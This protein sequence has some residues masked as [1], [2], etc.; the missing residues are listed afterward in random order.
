MDGGGP[1]SDATPDDAG[2]A[3]P[4]L[5]LQTGEPGRWVPFE[6]GDEVLL[7]R[8][9]QGSQHVYV[10]ARV[11]GAAEGPVRLSLTV[12]R[13]R[14]GEVVSLPFELR[15]PFEARPEGGWRQ[16]TGLTPVVPVPAD[17][18]DEEVSIEGRVTDEAGRSGEAVRRARVVW[19]PDACG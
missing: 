16:E 11:R 1:G 17:V 14:D 9:C 5:E 15:L 4:E 2:D 19:G 7:Q 8:G 3:P 18:L 13:L 10:S 12:R 6:D